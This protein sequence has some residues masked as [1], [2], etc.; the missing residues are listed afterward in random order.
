MDL[1]TE[2][3]KQWS[4]RCTL[5][6]SGRSDYVT[7]DAFELAVRDIVEDL[8]PKLNPGELAITVPDVKT[9]DQA[10]TLIFGL[11]DTLIETLNK[12]PEAAD[13]FTTVQAR[14]LRT[15]VNVYDYPDAYFHSMSGNGFSMQYA[16]CSKTDYMYG[17]DLPPQLRRLPSNQIERKVAPL[18]QGKWEAVNWPVAYDPLRPKDEQG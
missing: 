7:R 14:Q 11:A 3:E 5:G 15:V 10:K 1:K 18:Y 16:S 13:A 4:F 17:D 12:F 9:L 2:I 6:F 8:K